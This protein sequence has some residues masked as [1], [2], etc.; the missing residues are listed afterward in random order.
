MK[1]NEVKC[2]FC[3]KNAFKKE[4]EELQTEW[5][6]M[7]FEEK[8]GWFTTVEEHKKA[9]AREVLKDIFDGFE[10][11]GYEDMAEICFNSVSQEQVNSLQK[12][13]DDICSND[14]FIVLRKDEEITE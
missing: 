14:V 4:T 10:Q 5:A 6:S 12:L 13:L 2:E 9:D 3:V 11:Q 7:D 1:I 8:K